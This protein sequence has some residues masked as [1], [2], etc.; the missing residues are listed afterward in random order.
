[1][2]IFSLLLCS[3]FNQIAS[4]K[5]I[6]NKIIRY[7]IYFLIVGSYIVYFAANLSQLSSLEAAN[8][9][10]EYESILNNIFVSSYINISIIVS[11]LIFLF[12]STT[13]RFNGKVIY[14]L[15]SL[16]FS[17]RDINKG[18]LKFYSVVSLLIFL[19]FM[20]V[21]LP[22]FRLS[23]ISN[24][25]KV[26]LILIG[27]N[28][29]LLVF[30]SLELVK[31]KVINFIGGKKVTMAFNVIHIILLLVVG[32][33]FFYGR[34]YIDKYFSRT[35]VDLSNFIV[36][37]FCITVVLLV[38]VYIA[39]MKYID[40][41][42]LI[43]KSRYYN[44]PQVYHNAPN[45]WITSLLRARSFI[46]ILSLLL[47]VIV[48]ALVMNY[49]SELHQALFYT[50][51]IFY[52]S[53]GIMISNLFTFSKMFRAYN[54]SYTKQF[55]NI[56]LTLFLMLIP[57]L[58]YDCFVKEY[59]VC[60]QMC[61]ISGLSSIILNMILGSEDGLFSDMSISILLV[62]VFASLLFALQISWIFILLLI[63]LVLILYM[64]LKRGEEYE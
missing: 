32:V 47:G 27:I 5:L 53:A 49:K 7:S 57:V 11:I 58:I 22:A 18:L 29:N 9:T 37:T 19:I 20:A 52:F 15:K 64:L 60:S 8:K 63:A 21:L 1:M 10:P 54:I 36:V 35:N 59:F 40:N 43:P 17:N 12:V 14:L 33:Y 16:P 51:P 39:F 50:L 13:L 34:F 44:V 26:I 25:S 45:I 55:L 31:Q 42:I 4:N 38:L 23:S 24:V 28:V 6:K 46:I 2:K 48:M 62:F 3:C 56:L 61:A 41:Y 30:F